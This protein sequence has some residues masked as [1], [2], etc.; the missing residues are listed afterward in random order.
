MPVALLLAAL[1]FAFAADADNSSADFRDR[2][3]NASSVSKTCRYICID[4]SP[5]I[6]D[7]AMRFF[8]A[9]GCRSIDAVMFL[10]PVVASAFFFVL[11]TVLC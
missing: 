6:R 4:F 5:T 3:W 1:P 8:P 10:S 11:P 9:A 2:F 7:S